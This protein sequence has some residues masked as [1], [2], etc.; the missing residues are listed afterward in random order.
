MTSAFTVSKFQ[1]ITLTLFS[2]T[3]VQCK[4]KKKFQSDNKAQLVDP[5]TPESPK[6]VKDVHRPVSQVPPTLMPIESPTKNKVNEDT[7][8]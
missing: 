7:L 4:Q 1:I 5:N 6:S 2:F 3:F 8:A